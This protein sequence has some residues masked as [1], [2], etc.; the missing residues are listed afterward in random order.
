MKPIKIEHDK[1]ELQDR[2]NINRQKW[3]RIVLLVILGYE[4]AGALSGGILLIA[5]P[6]GRIMDMP[7]DIMHGVF[8]DFLVPGIILFGLGILNT[9]AF[10]AVIRKSRADWIMA[11]LALGGMI[12][13]FSVE[14]AILQEI[15]WLH[16]VWGMPV[17]LGGLVALILFSSQCAVT[18]KALL[19]CG[20]LSSLLYVVLNVF[21]PMLW[22]ANNCASQTVSE[23][24]A[25]GAPTRPIWLW[26]CFLYTLL[27]IVFAWGV[28]KSAAKNH[29][30]RIAG[31]LLIAY[32]ALGVIWPFAPM[33]LREVLAAGGGTISDK[34][35]IALAVVTEILFLLALGF[36]AAALGK[37]FR[38]YSIAT[39]VILLFFGVLTF[40]DAPGVG[41]NQPTP[42]IGVWERINIGVF[43]LWIVVLAIVLLRADKK[44]A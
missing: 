23:L 4:A 1:K 5:A 33:H 27:M 25:I 21:I 19:V 7:I 36:T 16:I 29:S 43:L 18:Q 2:K 13:W 6:D 42:F 11:G 37:R 26:L 32:A 44:S 15:H 39:F 22:P 35:H 17:Y 34:M 24:S 10:V 38:F 14:I 40:L 9:A 12:V 41:A 30:L 20:I 28:W 8:R 3:L 31:A